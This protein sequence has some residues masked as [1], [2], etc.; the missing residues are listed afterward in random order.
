MNLNQVL[1]SSGTEAKL[2]TLLKHIIIIDIIDNIEN[3]DILSI[4]DIK[5][6]IN[7]VEGTKYI[8]VEFIIKQIILYKLKYPEWNF[9][10]I[11]KINQSTESLYNYCFYTD[12]GDN[13]IITI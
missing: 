13:V 5:N 12:K 7:S 9:L 6:I 10:K 11:I 3:Y 4:F 8:D 2:D 1:F